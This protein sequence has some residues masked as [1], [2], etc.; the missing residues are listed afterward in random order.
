M[1]DRTLT[2]VA[3]EAP[4]IWNAIYWIGVWWFGCF[5]GTAAAHLDSKLR[6]C[7]DVLATGVACGFLAFGVTSFGYYCCGGGIGDGP[8]W[9]GIAGATG[10]AWKHK[11]KI[12]SAMIGIAVRKAVAVNNTIAIDDTNSESESNGS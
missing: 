6:S 7:W 9:L 1:D 8:V 11:D 12:L 3:Q 5:A 10:L 4:N 2:A